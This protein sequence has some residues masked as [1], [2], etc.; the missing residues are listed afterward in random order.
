MAQIHVVSPQGKIKILAVLSALLLF[1][2]FPN[3]N[4]FRLLGSRWCHSHCLDASD[5]LEKGI[6]D[7]LPNGF[8]VF[9]RSASRH[10]PPLSVCEHLCYNGGIPTISG[11]HGTLFCCFRSVDEVCA[12]AFQCPVF[13]VR[14]MYLDSIGVGSELDDNRVSMGKYRLFTME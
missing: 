10:P 13:S 4:L 2:S 8:S 5:R 6:L 14:C 9:R 11:I 1:L 7:R 12:E 3:S